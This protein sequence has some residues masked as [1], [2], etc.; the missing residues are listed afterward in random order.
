MKLLSYT[1]RKLSLLLFLLMAVWGVLFYYAI[2]EE[3]MDETDDTL[4]NYR[5]ILFRHALEDPSILTGKG[6]DIMS[7][8]QFR[9]ITVE[10]ALNYRE[11]FYDST[12]YIEIE[13]ED[14][15]VRVLKSCFMMP[16]GQYY[17]LELHISTLEREDM[18]E[19]MLWYLSALY[20]LFLVCTVIGTR[21]VLKK[22]FR[23]LLHLLD[24][25]ECVQPGKEVPP[26]D[27]ETRIQE[28]K[29]LGEAALAMS[30][31]SYK[32]YREQKEFIE[33]AS[34]ELQTPLAIARGKVEL[35]AESEKLT[36]EQMKSL[37]DIY[38]TL[39]RAVK[40]NKSLLLLSRI[41]NGQYTER[42]DV[43]FNKL[44]DDSLPDLMEVYEW[45][46]IHLTR[47]DEGEFVLSCNRLLGQMLVSNLLKNALTHNLKGGDMHLLITKDSL[48]ISNS[49]REAL[50]GEKIFQRF[51]H[52][53]NDG[54]TSTG[55]G[56]SIARS[57]ANSYGLTLEYSW[58]G[59]HRFTLTKG[60]DS[61]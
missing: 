37:D 16:D 44:V 36:E 1:Y 54:G 39:G 57:V 33:N 42:T 56:L 11:V 8:Y 51:Y 27:N 49:G 4:E 13:D 2:M 9:A 26:L 29:K 40:L 7:S 48:V 15:P 52:S 23:P 46:Q 61:Y 19:A 38:N 31:R 53:H 17:E 14:E 60:R 59:M 41:E 24:W 45:K 21:V 12:A 28:F 35:L 43:S 3:I 25:L 47:R 55:L 34:H 32:A 58:E 22:A 6:R 10:E 5:D 30:I 18:I 20:L 50:D